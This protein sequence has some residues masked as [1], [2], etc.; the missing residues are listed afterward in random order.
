MVTHLADLARLQRLAQ[1]RADMQMRKFSVFRTHMTALQTRMEQLQAQMRAGY[2]TEGA[3][4]IIDAR[5]SH[6][7]TRAAAQELRRCEAELAG[8]RPRFEAMRAQA[9]R[10]HGRAGVLSHLHDR[11]AAEQRAR[12]EARAET[13]SQ[14]APQ[15]PMLP[16][17]H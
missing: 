9:V 14:P 16:A 5:Q 6:A 2:A 4:S 15:P 8:L 17:R 7:L 11:T 3:F 12:V 1:L 10:E 13:L